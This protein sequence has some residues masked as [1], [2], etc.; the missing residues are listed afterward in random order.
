MPTAFAA[1]WGDGGPTIG[2][3]ASHRWSLHPPTT[4]ARVSV[5]GVGVERDGWFRSDYRPYG[6]LCGE[7]P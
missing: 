7:N 4:E 2:Y 6:C 1:V 3:R 5:P